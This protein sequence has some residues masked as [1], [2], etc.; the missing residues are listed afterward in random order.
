MILCHCSFIFIFFSEQLGPV[1]NRKSKTDLLVF[2]S[3]IEMI[4]F[5]DSSEL[6]VDRVY[7][8]INDKLKCTC[9]TISLSGVHIQRKE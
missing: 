1:N 2:K 9:E 3:Y 8:M 6:I 7:I 4:K 5:L